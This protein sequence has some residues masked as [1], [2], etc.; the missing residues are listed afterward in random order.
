MRLS[1]PYLYSSWCRICDRLSKNFRD[2]IHPSNNNALH[3]QEI[4]DERLLTSN[5]S[6]DS[7]WHL[8]YLS[9]KYLRSLVPVLEQHWPHLSI[10]TLVELWVLNPWSDCM[11]RLRHLKRHVI[12]LHLVFVLLSLLFPVVSLR[13]HGHTDIDSFCEI[14]GCKSL[15]YQLSLALLVSYCLL[16]VVSE[17]FVLFANLDNSVRG[18]TKVK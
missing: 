9:V 6:M 12:L 3:Q 4:T 10:C 11:L 1:G 14:I 8:R 15:T 18:Y 5:K 2:I 16:L 13:T 17:P 7:S